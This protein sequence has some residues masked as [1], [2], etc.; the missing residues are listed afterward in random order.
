MITEA[1]WAAARGQLYRFLAGAFL[2]PPSEQSVA[3]ILDGGILPDLAWQFGA[4]AIAE[5]EQFSAAFDGDWD[6]LNQE[7]QSLFTVPLGRYVTPYEAVYRDERV[8]EGEVVRGLLMGP[9]T[10]AIKALYRDAGV[11]VAAEL[12]EL[13]D[14]IGLELGCMQA[15]CDAE[16][17]GRQDGDEE[18]VTRATELQRR[19]LHGHLLQWAP[20]LCAR[21]RA[22]ARGP[23]YQGIA[24]L[25]EAF[26]E[27]EAEALG[28]PAGARP[29]YS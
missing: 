21:V 29:T 28:R 20:S 27:Q 22:N 17:Q 13:P 25:T 5:L 26:L 15:L 10:L 1:A 7:Y 24:T 19:L 2:R 18:T 14:H 16:A 4:E 3:P 6:A 8:V 11:E 23:F 12:G 9:S